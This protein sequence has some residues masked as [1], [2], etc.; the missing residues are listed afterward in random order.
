MTIAFQILFN[1]GD[2]EKDMGLQGDQKL[3]I[4]VAF[5]VE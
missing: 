3:P 4:P 5:A 1:S 2:N